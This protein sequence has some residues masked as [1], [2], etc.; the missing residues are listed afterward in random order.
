MGSE[1]LL[2]RGVDIVYRKEKTRVPSLNTGSMAFDL[3]AAQ[4]LLWD[5]TRL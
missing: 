2:K 4:P 5:E 3:A 1:L